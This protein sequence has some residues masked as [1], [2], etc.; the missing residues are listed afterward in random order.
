[1]RKSHSIFF[2]KLLSLSSI[3]SRKN[4]AHSA[5]VCVAQWVEKFSKFKIYT[6]C[7]YFWPRQKSTVSSLGWVQQN[8]AAKKKSWTYSPWINSIEEKQKEIYRWIHSNIRREPNTG[9]TKKKGSSNLLR[10]SPTSFVLTWY[11]L[12]LNKICVEC[13]ER[14]TLSQRGLVILPDVADGWLLIR[15]CTRKRKKI[16]TIYHVFNESLELQWSFS[17]EQ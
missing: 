8:T 9:E 5:H 6:E 4:P 1:M 13:R 7:V 16:S 11:C 17:S 3:N 10:T 2:L 14:R 12:I 15:N